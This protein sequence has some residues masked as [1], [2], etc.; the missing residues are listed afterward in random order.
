MTKVLTIVVTYNGMKW[1][2]KCLSSIRESSLHSDLFIV[3]NGSTD[4]SI[5]FI[6]K[7]VPDAVFIESKENLG[8]GAA[9]NLGLRYAVENGYDFVYLL[10]QDAWIEPD[11]LEKMT[12]VSDAHPEYG[13]LSPLQVNREKTRLDKNFGIFLPSTISSDLLCSQPLQQVYETNFIMAAHWLIPVSVLRKVGSFSP[14]FKHYGEDNN[15]IDRMKYKG[16]K[17]GIVPS[18][19]GVH[20]REDRPYPRDKAQYRNYVSMLTMLNNPAVSFRFPKLLRRIFSQISNPYIF[21]WSYTF[22]SL[23]AYLKSRRYRKQYKEEG[24]FLFED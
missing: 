5:D 9:N 23:G 1:L 19:K 7:N 12:A 18:V 22:K 11:L 20:D 8:F 13:I 3:D 4:G 14:A 10:N 24:P 15:L 21:K 6:K 17:I 16:Y 2:D